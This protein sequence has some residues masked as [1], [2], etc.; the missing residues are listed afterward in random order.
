MLELRWE[1]ADS[2]PT[3]SLIRILLKI[4]IKFIFMFP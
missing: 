1:E 3:L 2:Y 4:K